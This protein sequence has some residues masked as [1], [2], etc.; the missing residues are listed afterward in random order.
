MQCCE[1]RN[2]DDAG[3]DNKTQSLYSFFWVIPRRL[4]LVLYADVSEYY[5]PFS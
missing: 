4:S 3:D 5:V 1:V 2:V